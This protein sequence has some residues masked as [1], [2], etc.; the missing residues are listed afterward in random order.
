MKDGKCLLVTVI[1]LIIG[2]TVTAQQKKSDREMFKDGYILKPSEIFFAPPTEKYEPI[3]PRLYSIE[4]RRKET[5]VTFIQPIYFDS[6]WVTYGYGYQLRDKKSGD[7]YMVRKYDGDLP[8][9]RLLIVRGCNRKNILI[10][11]VFPKLKKK[12]KVIDIVETPHEKDLTPSN[13]D[14]KKT[15]IQNVVVKDYLKKKQGKIYR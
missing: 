5:I 9:D 12:V 6:Q 7:T 3:M 10:S 4:K 1:L 13:A 14:S 8:M 2:M 11:L 15:Y